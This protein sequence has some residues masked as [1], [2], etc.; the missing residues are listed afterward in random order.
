MLI[1]AQGFRGSRA[2]GPDSSVKISEIFHSLQ[3]EG[4]L[5]GMPSIFVRTSG[6]NLRCRWCDTPYT[7]WNPEGEEMTID[8]IMAETRKYPATY[9]VVTGGEPMISPGIG[10][11]TARMKRA[12]MH[13]TIETAGTVWAGV[14]CDL[15]SISPK[16]RNST[17]EGQFAGQHERLRI[18]PEVLSKLMAAH[19]Y[20]LKFVVA[21]RSD[22]DE[23]RAL[24]KM[25]GA[26]RRN[27]ILMPEGV[28][29]EVLRERTAWVA[30]LCKTEGFRFTPRLHIELYGNK[31]GV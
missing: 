28:D 17:P 8:A 1:A 3:G 5:V 14:E 21:E 7:S 27:V 16:L 22:L 15:L 10:E 4:G 20:Q 18:Q 19:E 29:I 26:P 12:G 31:R 11:L 30:E 25:L 23:I 24:V 2:C 13:V 9:V 6:C